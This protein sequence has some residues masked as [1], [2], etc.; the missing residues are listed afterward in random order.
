MQE[1]KRYMVTE[2]DGSKTVH[3]DGPFQ[4]GD[5]ALCGH[6]L[7]GDSQMKHSAG[8]EVKKKVTCTEC[9]RIID[10]VKKILIH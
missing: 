1:V 7:L 6:D 3:Y 5:Q 9:K 8:K 2:H 10:H 4:P